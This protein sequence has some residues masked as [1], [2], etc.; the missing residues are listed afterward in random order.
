[1]FG[2]VLLLSSYF[3]DRKSKRDFAFWGYLFG[4]L[5]FWGGLSVL[6]WTSELNWF[7]YFSINMVMMVGSIFLGRNVLM[8][9]GAFGVFEYL[10]HL[11]YCVFEHSIVFPFAISFIGIVLVTFGILYQKYNSLI[12]ASIVSMMRMTLKR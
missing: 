7:L 1:V 2:G 10:C 11:A 5:S 8:V 6:A 12:Q 3:T 4:A 9:F